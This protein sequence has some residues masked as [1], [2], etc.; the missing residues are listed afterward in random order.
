ML[1]LYSIVTRLSIS[2]SACL[3]ACA[4]EQDRLGDV[5]NLV[6][7]EAGLIGID[8]RDVVGAGNVAVIGDDES[9]RQVRLA[10]PMMVPRGMV[11]RIVAP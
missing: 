5:P 11:E 9:V 10:E 2:I 7:G 3:S 1:R 6:D 4:I 8:Q